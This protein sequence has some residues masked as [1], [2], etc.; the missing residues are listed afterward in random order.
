MP[1]T[2]GSRVMRPDEADDTS[3]LRGSNANPLVPTID[4]RRA[5]SYPMIDVVRLPPPVGSR[6]LHVRVIRRTATTSDAPGSS[7]CPPFGHDE[8]HFGLQLMADAARRAGA[9]LTV[10]TPAGEG[11]ALRLEVPRR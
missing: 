9:G 11:T 1:R 4:L 10:T 3:D 7:T 6:T 5:L 8:G 2:V